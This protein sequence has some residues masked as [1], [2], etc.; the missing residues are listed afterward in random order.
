MTAVGRGIGPAMAVLALVL[1]AP[2]GA[3]ENL[4]SGK[5]GAQLYAADC[6]ICHKSPQALNKPGGLFGLSGFLREHYTASKELAA[7]IA[8]YLQS[9]G[10]APAPTK[11]AG[12]RPAKD[13]EKAKV[14]EEKK[15]K[16]K[17]GEAKGEEKAKVGEE[18]KAKS[19]SDEAKG[20][21]KAKIGDRRRARPKPARPRARRRPR[22]KKRPKSTRRK[23]PSRRPTRPNPKNPTKLTSPKRPRPPSRR[24]RANPSKSLNKSP[25]GRSAP[26]SPRVEDDRAQDDR[27]QDR[28]GEG[29]AIERERR[30]DSAAE[31]QNEQTEIGR[32]AGR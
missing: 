21:E 9:S 8:A 14:D 12:K 31:G 22:A 1:T 7:A 2:A 17:S 4:D 13:E 26:R 20:D 29:G 18:K 25:S 24:P 27:T 15:A 28:R 19:K 32:R 16:P 10:N 23:S 5:T 11:R 6:A 30:Q 3:Q